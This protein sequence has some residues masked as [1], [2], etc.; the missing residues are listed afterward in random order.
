MTKVTEKGVLSLAEV[1]PEG[2]AFL[3]LASSRWKTKLFFLKS[4][5]LAVF[6]RLRVEYL[7]EHRASVSVPYNWM[8]TNPFNSSYF[9]VL[10]MAAELSTGISCMSA[11]YKAPQKRSMLLN[12][13][14]GGFFK[15]AK[16]RITFTC[17]DQ[18]AIYVATQRAK[19]SGQWEEA[20]METIGRNAAEEEVAKFTFT[21]AIK[22]A[23]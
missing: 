19:T 14:V 12:N 23:T 9:A 10:T 5:P 2:V 20:I 8:N 3:N 16:E 15:K 17:T 1:N 21:W 6:A 22:V 11:V 4:L 18:Q 7:D 13:V